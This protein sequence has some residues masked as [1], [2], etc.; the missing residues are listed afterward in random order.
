VAQYNKPAP[1][2]WTPTLNYND[3]IPFGTYIV[4]NQLTHIFPGT[5]LIKTDKSVY[6]TFHDTSLLAGNYIILSKQVN[7]NKNDFTELIK[8]VSAGNSVFISAFTFD[9]ILKDTLKIEQRYEAKKAEPTLNFTNPELRRATDYKLKKQ[10]ASKYFS[11]FDTTRASII[12]KN[13]FDHAIVLSYKFGTGKLYLCANPLLFSNYNL[14]TDDGADYAAKTLSFMPLAQNTYWD[15][16]QNGDIQ[17]DDSPLRVFFTH[18]S[19]QWA[20]YLSIATILIF[21][22]F[23]M[24]RRQRII[25]VIEPLTNSTLDFV[26]VVGQVYYEKRDNANIAHK[27]ILYFLSYLRDA[28]QI[29]TTKF[30]S[31]FVEILTTKLALDPA[32]SN[33]L[34]GYLQYISTQH[35]VTDHELIE[36]NKLIEKFYIKSR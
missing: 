12:S 36:L 18:P 24:K 14:L 23:E 4:Y 32:F 34:A 30:D 19:L 7:L 1:V 15:E 3:K 5:K 8:F 9:G 13:N 27:K 11:D 25:P 26:T 16:F 22:L 20:Y 2:D 35:K 21:V 33:E 10:I 17:L 28:Y 6:H 31:E 29:K